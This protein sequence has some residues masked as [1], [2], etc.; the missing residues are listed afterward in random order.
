MPQSAA[1]MQRFDTGVAEARIVK[2]G[3]TV[4]FLEAELLAADGA[5]MTRATS[6]GMLVRPRKD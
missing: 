4:V 2:W 1:A 3:R 5:V 6:T